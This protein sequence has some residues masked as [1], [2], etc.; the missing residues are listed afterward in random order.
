MFAGQIPS[1]VLDACSTLRQ[2]TIANNKLEGDIPFKLNDCTLLNSL[3]LNSNSF[4]GALSP[5]LS[6][7]VSLRS[8]RFNQNRFAGTIPST[9]GRLTSALQEL[10]LHGNQLSGTLPSE[11]GALRG[12][13]SLCELDDYVD[14][15]SN[16]HVRLQDAVRKQTLR[17]DSLD[18][19]LHVGHDQL[20]SPKQCVRQR[21]AH[22]DQ[23]AC[24]PS[25]FVSG[26]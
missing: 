2:L 8:L 5:F 7:L 23:S 15:L 9:L 6:R 10:H 19:R 25:L 13:T 26:E 20:E 21:R 3:Q 11:V 14:L 18:N 17:P 1:A 24:E 12:I 16:I 22:S 4:V